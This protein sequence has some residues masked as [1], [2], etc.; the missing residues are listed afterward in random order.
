MQGWLAKDAEGKSVGATSPTACQFCLIGAL[1]RC[2]FL[3]TKRSSYEEYVAVRRQLEA[4]LRGLGHKK[5]EL[6]EFNDDPAT[7]HADVLALL[8][9]VD[10]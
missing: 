6:H 7:T 4:A 1:V 8:E 10:V 2:Y 9:L 5:W 3:A